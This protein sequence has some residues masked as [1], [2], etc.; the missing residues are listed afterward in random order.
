MVSETI[1]DGVI[2]DNLNVDSIY[3]SINELILNYNKRVNYQKLSHKNFYLTHKYVSSKIDFYRSEKLS[4]KKN[5]FLK[6]KDKSLR[7]LHVTNFN[8]R[9]DGRL[10]FNTGKR[11]NNGFV[12]LGNSVLE[13]SDRDIQKNTKRI[14][15]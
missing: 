4:Y 6:I 9:L 10:F 5:I 1:T 14:L 8:E 12:R 15:I 7:I 11:I 2:I 3:S 13:F